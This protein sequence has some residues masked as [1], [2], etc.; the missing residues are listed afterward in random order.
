[1]SDIMEVLQQLGELDWAMRRPPAD[2]EGATL[3][4]PPMISW[5]YKN[6]S[7]EIA[8]FL[9]HAIQ[10]FRGSVPW[11]FS[12]EQRNWY[13]TVA[14]LLESMKTQNLQGTRKA[15]QELMTQEPDFC[16]RANAELA[17]LSD[18]IQHELAARK[19]NM[20]Q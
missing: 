1:M 14:K 12:S 2:A 20:D 10:R 5:R 8:Q 18:Q 3:A 17:L 4:F 6:P 19:G 16:R 15:A 13:L 7:P 11:T 9:Q